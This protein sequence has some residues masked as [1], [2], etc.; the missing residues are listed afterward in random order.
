MDNKDSIFS[1]STD[2]PFGQTQLKLK[3]IRRNSNGIHLNGVVKT[4]KKK[5]PKILPIMLSVF[6]TY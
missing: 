3:I 6:S 1:L 2:F 4:I 5:P